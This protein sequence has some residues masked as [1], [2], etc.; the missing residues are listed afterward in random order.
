MSLNYI[1][2][3][4]NYCRNNYSISITIVENISSINSVR[5]SVGENMNNKKS[6]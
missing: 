4:N 1:K 5:I 6:I 2:T 3:N